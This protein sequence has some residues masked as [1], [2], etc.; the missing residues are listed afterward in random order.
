MRTAYPSIKE[1][2]GIIGLLIG[3]MLLTCPI[4]LAESLIGKE[5]TFLVYYVASM[6]IALYVILS[7]RK[8]HT[9]E[10]AFHFEIENP[11]IVP[12]VMVATLGLEFG[13]AVPL[14]SLIPV[15]DW[16]IEYVIE[17]SQKNGFFS[18]LVIVVAAPILEELLFRGIIL[19]GFL[20]RY[21]PVKAILFSSFLFGFIHLNPWQFVAA[22]LTGVLI[23]WVYYRTRSLTLAIIIHMTNNL[24]AFLMNRISGETTA[25]N[26]NHSLVEAYGDVTLVITITSLA[27][28]ALA[29]SVFSLHRKMIDDPRQLFAE[30]PRALEEDEA[31]SNQINSYAAESPRQDV[32]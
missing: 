11:A 29:V 10:T 6:G 1:S 30:P 26:V 16:L 27:I 25:E 19:D 9:V 24:S 5:A 13:V 7:Q 28:L 31:T 18:F 15:P 17:M 32:S 22:G 21:S 14:V 3:C 23:G 20:K 12:F 8:K 2:I 4:L